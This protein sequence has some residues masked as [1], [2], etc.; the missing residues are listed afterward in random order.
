MMFAISTD[1]EAKL[2]SSIHVIKQEGENTL[3]K[4]KKKSKI[5][6]TMCSPVQ[7]KT[8]PCQ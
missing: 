2:S 4:K 1:G 8:R 6:A 7:T 3:L 5:P